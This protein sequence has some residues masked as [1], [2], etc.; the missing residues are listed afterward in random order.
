MDNDTRDLVLRA[1]AGDHAALERL[2]RRIDARVLHLA[3]RL[4][5][6]AEDARDV[7]QWVLLKVARSV[8]AFCGDATFETWLHRI[9]INACRDRR[10]ER[11]AARRAVEKAELSAPLPATAVGP[12]SDAERHELCARVIAAVAALPADEREVVVLRH[13]EGLRFPKIAEILGTAETTLKSRFQRALE[14]LAHS[15]PAHDAPGIHGG[16]DDG[17]S[18]NG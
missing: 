12:H 15:I 1:R 14:R 3:H 16:L 18:R 11:S 4:L 13:Y 10:R 2:L 9:V 7:R 5:C 6:D 8:S 17:L